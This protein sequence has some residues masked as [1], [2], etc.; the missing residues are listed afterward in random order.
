MAE[1]YNLGFYDLDGNPV[2][3]SKIPA[4]FID[5]MKST[6][7]YQLDCKNNIGAYCENGTRMALSGVGRTKVKFIA[8]LWRVQRLQNE[9]YNIKCVRD[10]KF[11]LGKK[12]DIHEKNLF[13]Y[14]EAAEFN[15][16][17]Y[18]V[19][20][21]KFDYIVAKYTTKDGTIWGYGETV[22]DARA[23]LGIAL[24]DKFGDMIHRAVHKEKQSIH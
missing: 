19:L 23:F 24:F 22:P 12:L 14:Y 5:S 16:N 17:C 15:G 9:T 11:I 21:P 8:G 4:E 10:K 7:N 6:G 13:E 18:G 3:D 2:P 1:T 20:Q